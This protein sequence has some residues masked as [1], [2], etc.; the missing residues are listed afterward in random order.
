M[1][2]FDS[3]INK[4]IK[5]I[6]KATKNKYEALRPSD[7]KRSESEEQRLDNILEEMIVASPSLEK[8]PNSEKCLDQILSDIK[9]IN[10]GAF[11][12]EFGKDSMAFF[13]KYVLHPLQQIADNPSE[14]QHNSNIISSFVNEASL[15]GVSPKPTDPLSAGEPINNLVRSP[16]RCSVFLSPMIAKETTRIRRL[17]RS[18]HRHSQNVTVLC[19]EQQRQLFAEADIATLQYTVVGVAFTA[20]P[21]YSIVE[22]PMKVVFATDSSLFLEIVN[23]IPAGMIVCV[24]TLIFLILSN[25]MQTEQNLVRRYI[26]KLGVKTIAKGLSMPKLL[27]WLYFFG[28]GASTMISII[29][30]A[31]KEN[32]NYSLS[33]GFLM[34][35]F[36]ISCSIFFWLFLEALFNEARRLLYNKRL[37]KS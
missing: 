10:V 28:I 16:D 31:L 1:S 3:N 7:E 11:M 35:L 29:R 9:K 5:E 36:Y 30:T 8:Q 17:V 22:S 19:Y 21:I 34:L 24:T 14:L 18:H 20:L 37:C 12:K 25:T 13:I 26:Y 15:R 4:I 33:A 23:I 27:A 32:T 6:H 2:N